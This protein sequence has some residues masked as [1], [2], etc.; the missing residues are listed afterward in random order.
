M[1]G[2][3][4][5]ES[6]ANKNHWRLLPFPPAAAAWWTAGLLEGSSAIIGPPRSRQTAES[7]WARLGSRDGI[8][9]DSLTGID[10][11]WI[12][13]EKMFRTHNMTGYWEKRRILFQLLVPTTAQLSGLSDSIR[14]VWKDRETLYWSQREIHIWHQLNNKKQ[15]GGYK[16]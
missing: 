6:K 3:S 2:R 4:Y 10:L 13:N 12:V 15:Q 7:S 5:F 14:D 11:D 8:V 1:A 9:Q 16:V